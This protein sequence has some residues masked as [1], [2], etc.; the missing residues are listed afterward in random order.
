MK[1]NK[2]TIKVLRRI[3]FIEIDAKQVSASAKNLLANYL[4]A[5]QDCNLNMTEDLYYL[6]DWESTLRDAKVP[7]DTEGTKE[8]ETISRLCIAR[9][10]AYVR[11]V[12][13]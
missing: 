9:N 7:T 4:L 3:S 12:I 11:L 13:E 1:N 10:A 2:S 5:Y 8:L 6:E